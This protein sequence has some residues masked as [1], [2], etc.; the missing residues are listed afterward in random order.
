MRL[1]D[2]R[3]EKSHSSYLII[4]QAFKSIFSTENETMRLFPQKN[5]FIKIAPQVDS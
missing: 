4:Y 2:I 5:F 3:T 1:L